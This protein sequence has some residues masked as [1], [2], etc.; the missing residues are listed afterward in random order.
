MT[1]I[2]GIKFKNG[3]KVYYFDPG[4]L[5]LSEGQWCIV[6]TA[7]GKECGEVVQGNREVDD[8]EIIYYTIKPLINHSES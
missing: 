3:G 7:R 2:V 5:T 1:K 6:E 8:K 4:K